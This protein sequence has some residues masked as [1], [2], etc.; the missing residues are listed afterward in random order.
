MIPAKT[1]PIWRKIVERPED[2]QV[3]ALPT[4]MLF[5]RIKM[6]CR[7]GTTQGISEA[8]DAAYDFFVQNAET[9][10]ED[11]DEIFGVNK[12]SE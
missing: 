2:F 11:V 1:D 9:V 3:Q 7:H 5:M 12:E 4:K 6:L 10:R 8:I